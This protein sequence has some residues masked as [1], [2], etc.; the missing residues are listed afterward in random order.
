MNYLDESIAAKLKEYETVSPIYLKN[1]SSHIV[2][3]NN[4][5]DSN[6]GMHGGAIH[7]DQKSNVHTPPPT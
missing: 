7:I 6:I 4:T 1:V 2:F 3:I 5:F